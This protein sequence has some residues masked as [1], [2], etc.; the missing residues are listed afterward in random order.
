[1]PVQILYS[2][3]VQKIQNDVKTVDEEYIIRG[4]KGLKIKYFNVRG[5][6]VEKIVITGKDSEYKMKKTHNG[7][8]VESNLDNK[9][10]AT[11]LKS[12]KLKFA[13]EF[14]KDILKGG[15]REVR[16]IK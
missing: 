12:S 14:L 7:T 1:M 2:S 6:D 15:K 11:E 16:R 10:L 5:E 8:V 9:G 3:S 13:K 4:D